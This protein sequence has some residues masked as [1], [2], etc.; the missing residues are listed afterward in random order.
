MNPLITTVLKTNI[1]GQLAG[2]D[3]GGG[4]CLVG[5]PGIGK[6]QSMYALGKELNMSVIHISLPEATIESASGIPTFK[7]APNM[8]KYSTAG[9]TDSQSTQWSV[10]ELIAN[11]NNAAETG[12]GA[13]LF[14]DDLHK[15]P[16]PVEPYLYSLLGERKLGNYKLSSKVA[17]MGAMN[18][19][20]EAGFEGLE[21]PIKNRFSLMKIDF[22]FNY[23]FDNFGNR[24]HH[25]VASYLKANQGDIVGTESTDLEQFESPRSWTYLANEI[26]LHSTE[27]VNDNIEML[28]RMKISNDVAKKL[29]EHVTY[30]NKIDF[31]NVVKSQAMQSISQLKET[32][33]VLWAYIVNY[34]HTPTDAAYLIDLINHN[35]NDVTAQNFIGYLSGQIYIKFV[36]SSQ[37]GIAITAGQQILIEKFLGNYNEANHK[38]TKKEKELLET[39]VLANQSKLLDTVSDYIH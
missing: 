24:L 27:F 15:I 1:S 36:M 20:E 26:G 30:I 10:P 12:N 5:P 8:D 39:K 38:L 23:W 16:K 22:D 29:Y 6:T 17:I 28:A 21:A 19:S 25:Y 13:I 11:C 34:I 33:K 35:S 31:D 32:D 9:V 18:D 4:V 14:L 7:P 3:I 37:E 2:A